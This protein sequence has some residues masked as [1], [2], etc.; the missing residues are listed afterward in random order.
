MARQWHYQNVY[1]CVFVCVYVGGEEGGVTGL[2]S[3]WVNSSLVTW[4]EALLNVVQKLNESEDVG[5]TE[6]S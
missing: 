2:W 6:A 3:G 4:A 5:Q 1:V